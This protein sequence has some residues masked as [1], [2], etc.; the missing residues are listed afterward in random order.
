MKTLKIP[1]FVLFFLFSGELV[2]SQW[3]YTSG[4]YAN[5]GVSQSDFS[6]SS[7]Q[8]GW[9]TYIGHISP[10]SGDVFYLASTND[11][12]NSWNLE[13]VGICGDY[14]SIGKI[15]TAGTDTIYCFVAS[16]N[17]SKC[18]HSYD[19]GN[20][21]SSTPFE[22]GTWFNDAFYL[23][24][25]ILYVTSD[26]KMFRYT[27]DS[28]YTL[29]DTDS[30]K[31]YNSHI[32]FANSKIGYLIAKDS[33]YNSLLLFTK[34]GGDNWKT[35]KKPEEYELK[36]LYFTSDSVGYIACSEGRILKT[37]DYGV[38][39]SELTTPTNSDLYDIQFV[40]DSCGYC[41]GSNGAC[42]Y[43]ID[44]GLTWL[45]D[46]INT[47]KTLQKIQMFSMDNGYI[48]SWDDRVYSKNNLFG[49]SSIIDESFNIYPNPTSHYLH[50][51]IPLNKTID[52]ISIYNMSGVK[53]ILNQSDLRKFDVS[54][55]KPGLYFINITVD[56]KKYV[57]KI[58]KE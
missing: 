15:I 56:N 31:L 58:I 43:T 23:K 30:L 26:D 32:F 21:W 14:P 29:I 12:G 19:G 37:T 46:T 50:L 16:E 53:M 52:D 22:Y 44:Y 39:F 38:N 24:K 25:D 27:P 40:N 54:N 28:L 4:F 2:F 20:Q 36:N 34:D 49:I 3:E 35:I 42:I 5:N 57:K 17:G 47:T 7:P 18:L 8:Y 45:N 51:N 13:P 1:L 55:F 33:L 48:L 6:F 11:Y 9:A 10:S 41:V